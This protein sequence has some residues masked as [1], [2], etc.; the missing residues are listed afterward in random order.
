MQNF[1]G[2]L[3][4]LVGDGRDQR[5]RVA[6]IQRAAEAN[7]CESQS[8]KGAGFVLV[9]VAIPFGMNSASVEFA[10]FEATGEDAFIEVPPYST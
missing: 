5:E 9:E 6:W 1:D 4:Y 3:R 10:V 8:E 2:W 7:G